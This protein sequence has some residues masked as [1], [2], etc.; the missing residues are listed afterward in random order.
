MLVNNNIIEELCLDAGGRKTEKAKTYANEQ[1]IRIIKTI[2]ESENDFEVY[3]KAYGNDIYD[4]Y[5]EV[6]RGEIQSIQCSCPDYYRTYGVC[7]H[8]LATIIT[9]NSMK[10]EELNYKNTNNKLENQNNNKKNIKN[11]YNSFKQIVKTLYNEELEEIDSELDIQSKDSGTIKIEPKIIYDKFTKEMK[12]EFKI[13]NKRMYKLK[14]LSEFY[15]F[16]INNEF[17]RYGDKLEFIHKKEMFE[18]GR[19]HV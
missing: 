15:K 3:G 19:A 5:I 4:T 6:K 2:Y 12:I 11:N 7:K 16:M 18:I 8:S 10:Q 17:Y 9:F 13:G 14:N 1:R